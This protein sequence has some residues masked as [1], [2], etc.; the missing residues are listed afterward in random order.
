MP[1]VSFVHALSSGLLR[2][3]TPAGAAALAHD[4]LTA[5]WREQRSLV[6]EVQ[7]TGFTARG[8]R[9]GGVD[10]VLLRGAGQLIVNRVSRVGFTPEVGVADLAAFLEAA[11]RTPRE[12]SDPGLIGAIRAAAPRGI[13]LST[14]GGETYRPPAAPEPVAHARPVEAEASPA[15]ADDEGEGDGAD[16]SSFE[17]VEEITVFAEPTAASRV[18]AAD[19]DDSPS[20]GMYHF[21]KA[22]T[23]TSRDEKSGALPRMLH[24]TTDMVRFN[25]LVQSCANGARRYLEEGDTAAAVALLEALAV[26]AERTDRS[27]VFRDTAGMSL[28]AIGTKEN[29]PQLGELLQSGAERERIL[30]VL[31]ALGGEAVA[32][33]DGVIFRTADIEVRRAIFRRILGVDGLARQ[34]FTR[35]MGESPQR[36]RTILEL[37][38]MPEVDPEL[39]AR[40]LGEGGSHTD[41][42]VRTDSARYAT[43]LGGRAGLRVLVELLSD[44]DHKVRRSALQGLATLA[45]PASVPFLSRFVTENADEDLQLAAVAA[46]GKIRSPEALPPLL[47]IVN[48]RQLFAGKK[49]KSLK[50][51]AIEAVG[52]TGVPAAHNVLKLIAGGSDGELAEHA[53]RV[54][55]LLE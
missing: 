54:L 19:S 18:V 49:A 20:S 30:N 16:L 43:A 5:L 47:A 10:P 22:A 53:R 33:A 8:L 36:A 51:A 24:E 26:E 44:A 46:L 45:D 11:S 40:W 15:Y 35:A 31:F 6:L 29:L 1:A 38:T 55:S 4:A 25:D 37:A 9:V 39:A 50:V 34:L 23:T 42:A 41:P 2:D 21:F 32:I 17:I 52:R 48:K 28:R 3:A 13:Y 7:F 27:R 12:L 14:S